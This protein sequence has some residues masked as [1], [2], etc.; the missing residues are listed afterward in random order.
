VLRAEPDLAGPWPPTQRLT[1]TPTWV[2]ERPIRMDPNIT[3]LLVAIAG[4][5]GTLFSPVL[6]QYLTRRA[7]QQELNSQRLQRLDEQENERRRANL[8]ERRECYI[9]LNSA[10]RA[11]RRALSTLLFEQSPEAKNVLDESRKIFGHRYAEVQLMAP[12]EVLAAAGS[13]SWELA[14]AFGKVRRFVEEPR[15]VRVEDLEELK[16]YI[17]GPVRASIR[18]LRNV[19]RADLGVDSANEPDGLKYVG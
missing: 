15:V 10:A 11:H 18:Q 4:V 16:E 7:R 17:N 6:S 1:C 19:M 2:V 9:A 13:V 8:R 14:H 12:E 5:I 3:A